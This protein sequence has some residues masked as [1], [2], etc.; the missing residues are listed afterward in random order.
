MFV[1]FSDRSARSIECSYPSISLENAAK[2]LFFQPTARAEILD[3]AEKRRWTKVG[4]KQF[5]FPQVYFKYYYHWCLIV[6]VVGWR[7][8]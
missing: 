3:Y 8:T 2:L 1:I 6:V 7:A 5:V 4:D